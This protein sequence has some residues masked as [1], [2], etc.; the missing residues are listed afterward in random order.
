[1][2]SASSMLR[3][4]TRVT[5]KNIGSALKD[6]RRALLEADVNAAV[7][8]GLIDSVKKKAVGLETGV[9]PGNQFVKFIYDE[10]IR[11]MAGDDL[12]GQDTDSAALRADFLDEKTKGKT[13]TVLLCGLQ[14]AGKTT[15][16]AK[17]AKHIIDNKLGTPFLVAAD[18]YRPA[19]VE[20]LKI[21]G[22]S[23]D[24]EV[25][26]EDSEEKK[27]AVGV[28][29]RGLLAAEKTVKD[30]VVIV[31]TAG[32]QVVDGALMT[33][34][35]SIQRQTKPVE[36]LL[37]LDAMTGQQAAT[38]ALE[39]NTACPLTGAILTKLDGDA[40]GGAA[41]SI[42]GVAD[43]PVKF[44]GVGEK[45]TDLEPFYPGRMAS[46]ILG[47][48]DVVSLVEKA[49]KQISQA[50]AAKQMD[51]IQAGTFD[52]NDYLTQTKA[53]KDMGN[54]GGVA[55][56]LPGMAGVDASQ[57]AQ[58]DRRAK[59][60]GSLICSM[61]KLERQ[62]PTLLLR[63]KTALSRLKR[64]SKGSGRSLTDAQTFLQ[65]FQQMRTMMARMA[66]QGGGNPDPSAGPLMAP[67]KKKKKSRLG[68]AAKKA[69]KARKP[70]KG[71]G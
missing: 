2:A 11:V 42:R 8:K 71:F 12:A 44:V 13:Q 51:R 20:Q 59:V 39:F 62:N 34:L 1:M 54:F 26:A 60:H 7:V 29:R 37:V 14:G 52:F 68:A 22:K 47:M 36:T 67:P 38:L 69:S 23:I 17:L 35:K 45:V 4:K 49:E 66:K 33:E 10:L 25:Y 31:D 30:P 27:D 19:A 53:L 65:E 16:A 6:V 64:I 46:R 43:L 21:L 18:V 63:D 41:L 15:A 57:I 3:G 48:G 5:E 61:T 55:K 50:D 58:A 9:D 40:R 56:M 28:A 32:R 24:V 70:S